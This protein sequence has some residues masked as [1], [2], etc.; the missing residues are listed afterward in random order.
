[1]FLKDSK[2]RVFCILLVVVV[3]LLQ[4]S[5]FAAETKPQNE[6]FVGVV[7]ASLR[8]P[9][10]ANCEQACVDAGKKY[11]FKVEVLGG[12]D[13][14]IKQVAQVEDFITKGVD[15][16]L[17]TPVVQ[18]A[19]V[20]TVNKVNGAGIPVMILNRHLGEGAHTICYVGADDYEGGKKQAEL[21]AE[22]IGEQGNII[23]LQGTLGSSPQVDRQKGLEDSLSANYPNIKIVD[24]LP[25]DFDKSKAINT[26]QD[27]LV[28]YSTKGEIDGIISQ[29]SEMAMGAAQ[30]LEKMNRTEIKIVAFDNPSYVKEAIAQGSIFGTVLQDP[31]LQ[32]M[33]AM[34]TVWLYLSGNGDH[35]PKPLYFTP[36][37]KITKNNVNESPTAW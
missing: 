37:V 3:L 16:I 14:A 12:D 19:L 33:I 7:L 11:G 5:V 23:L 17:L 4:A 29:C 27:L 15:M 22:A 20:S 26:V 32:S 2:F 18:G 28:K 36:L 31:Y 24:K 34:D 1:M 35:I 30:V 8:H 25:C 10:W 9:F 13:D 6:W 21:I